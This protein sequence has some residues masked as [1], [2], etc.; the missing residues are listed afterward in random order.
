MAQKVYNMLNT[1][2]TIRVRRKQE[3]MLAGFSLQ[4]TFNIRI[5]KCG[6]LGAG[7]YFA[8]LFPQSIKEASSLLMMDAA[9]RSTAGSKLT[10]VYF[11]GSISA[12]YIRNS[13]RQ[14]NS[15]KA[16]CITVVSN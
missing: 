11:G 13:A 8:C 5:S 6:N 3:C 7:I 15:T 10:L 1:M 4:T 16:L 14:H 2:K 9:S 12:I